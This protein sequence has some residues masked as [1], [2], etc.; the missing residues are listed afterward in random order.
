M[1]ATEWDPFCT[2]G[3]RACGA[4]FWPGD[5]PYSEALDAALK[6]MVVPGATMV[7]TGIGGDELMSLRTFER[8]TPTS[9]DKR[10]DE[11]DLLTASARGLAEVRVEDVPAPVIP[12]PSLLAFACR[13]PVFL[14]SGAWPV[15]PLCAPELIR[16]CEWL[17]VAWRRGRRLHRER[18]VRAGL[19]GL[20]VS[21]PIPENFAAVM[22]RAMEKYG[23]TLAAGILPDSILVQLGL[24]DPSAVLKSLQMGAWR[25]TRVTSQ[26]Y[27]FLNVELALRRLLG[28][29]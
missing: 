20:W 5:E 21:P 10:P 27:E 28:T 9:P 11:L 15:S 24:I 25:T 17:P 12:E 22:A 13:S 26:L 1:P 4:V 6:E 3:R 16:F 29:R 23:P 7:F 2:A 14:R 8:S 18:L 19:D